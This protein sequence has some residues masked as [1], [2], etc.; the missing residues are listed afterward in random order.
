MRGPVC[1]QVGGQRLPGLL[2]DRR[3]TGRAGEMITNAM[4]DNGA[5]YVGLVRGGIYAEDR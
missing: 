3:E 1:V 2:L 4:P 5:R